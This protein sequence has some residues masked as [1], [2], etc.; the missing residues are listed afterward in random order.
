MNPLTMTPR[1]ERIPESAHSIYAIPSKPARLIE[2]APTNPNE[3]IA[4]V[5]PF[6]EDLRD[7]HLPRW[8]C[9]AI[10]NENSAYADPKHHSRL[11]HFYDNLLL[12]I[13]A[14]LATN[15]QNFKW[16]ISSEKIEIPPQPIFLT[17]EQLANP[18]IIVKDFCRQFSA[19]YTRSELW[20]FLEA[21]VS[22]AGDYPEGFC[23]GFALMSYDYVSCLTEAAYCLNW[24]K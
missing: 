3:T 18:E 8:L 13:D 21:G 2:K 24:E 23:P 14:L 17:E 19:E 1:A 5:S 15:N 22:L 20:H 10:I 12:L 4:E 16:E 7:T 11:F 6:I 9:T